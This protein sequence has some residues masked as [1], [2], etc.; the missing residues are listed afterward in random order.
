MQKKQQNT[1]SGLVNKQRHPRRANQAL[2]RDLNGAKFGSAL[3]G[4]SKKWLA[5]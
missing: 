2:P 3:S 1:V 4:E 5:F